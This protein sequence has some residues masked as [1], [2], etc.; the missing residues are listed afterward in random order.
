MLLCNKL[1]VACCSDK[2]IHGVNNLLKELKKGLRVLMS[3]TRSRLSQPLWIAAR[4][5]VT[6]KS[7]KDVGITGRFPRC[8]YTVGPYGSGPTSDYTIYCT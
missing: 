8:S 7:M 5:V 6:V 3:V 1:R 2:I 4:Y